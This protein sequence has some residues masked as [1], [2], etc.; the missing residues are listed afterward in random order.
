MLRMWENIHNGTGF[1]HSAGRNGVVWLGN[2]EEC[3]S[4]KKC[5]EERLLGIRIPF[6]SFLE[7]RLGLAKGHVLMVGLQVKG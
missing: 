6:M 7:R 5:T 2:S 3:V 1:A 4:L